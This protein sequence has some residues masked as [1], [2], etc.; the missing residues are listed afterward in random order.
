[1]DCTPE[2]ARTVVG[3]V[4]LSDFYLSSREFVTIDRA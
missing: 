2:A 1:M 3:A 4:P